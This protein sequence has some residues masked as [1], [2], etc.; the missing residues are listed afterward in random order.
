[1]L[2]GKLLEEVAVKEVVITFHATD[3]TLMSSIPRKDPLQT[4]LII[5]REKGSDFFE[6]CLNGWMTCTWR[7]TRGLWYARGSSDR[8]T[9][10]L[11]LGSRGS[12]KNIREPSAWCTYLDWV[13]LR[14]TLLDSIKGKLVVANLI[15]GRLHFFITPMSVRS[16]EE[17]LVLGE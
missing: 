9:S 13:Q 6:T 16:I 5:G 17:F 2:R 12:L 7:G 3:V 11:F 10:R 14:H 8:R 1:M 4:F 15:A